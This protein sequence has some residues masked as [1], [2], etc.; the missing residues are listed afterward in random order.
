[1]VNRFGQIFRIE[2][3]QEWVARNS[4]IEGPNQVDK[5]LLTPDPIK[6]CVHGLDGRRSRLLPVSRP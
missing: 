2:R 3:P 6:Q 5:E 1:M 4:E